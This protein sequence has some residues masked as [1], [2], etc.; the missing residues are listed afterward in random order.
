MN[1][2][3][4]RNGIDK[5]NSINHIDKSSNIIVLIILVLQKI[6]NSINH[7]DIFE[8]NIKFVYK[9]CIREL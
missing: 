1:S 9:Y 2:L 6:N 3:E 5:Q 7:I 4:E 8:F